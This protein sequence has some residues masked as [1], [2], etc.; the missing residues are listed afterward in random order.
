[1]AYAAVTRS[2]D[3]NA[4]MCTRRLYGSGRIPKNQQTDAFAHS[5][6]SASATRVEFALIRSL[7]MVA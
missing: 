3:F 7:Q 4:K 1:M 5:H 6:R 2:G